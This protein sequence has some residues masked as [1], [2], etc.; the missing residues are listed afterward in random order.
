MTDPGNENVILRSPAISAVVLSICATLV[1]MWIPDWASSDYFTTE[2]VVLLGTLQFLCLVL[3]FWSCLVAYR[4]Y[5][6]LFCPIL[7]AGVTFIVF[8]L[9]LNPTVIYGLRE[10]PQ[11][12]NIG[13]GIYVGSAHDFINPVVTTYLIL[14]I[15][16][17]SFV[18]GYKLLP[19]RNPSYEDNFNG[20]RATL[21]F[22]VIGFSYV[23]FGVIANYSIMGGL[24]SYLAK[25]VHFYSRPDEWIEANLSGGMKWTIM[26]KFLPVGLI[27][28]ALGL[29]LY[30]KTSK[31]MFVLFLIVASVANVFFNCSTGGRGRALTALFFSIILINKYVRQFTMKRLLISF[32]VLAALAFVLGVMRA[33]TYYGTVDAFSFAELIQEGTKLAEFIVKYLTNTVGT[34]VLVNEVD[35]SGIFFH[36]TAFAGLTGLL[37]GPTPLTTQEEIW[38]RTMGEFKVGNAR[39]GPPGELYFNYGLL[40]VIVGFV[41]IGL[42][43][44]IFTRAYVNNRSNVS[45]YG[46]LVAV[47]TAFTAHFVILA[48]LSYLPPYFTF[49]SVPFYAAYFAF[50]YRKC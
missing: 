44:S 35:I 42:L 38:W 1:V 15:A 17:I 49:F 9:L 46:G 37:G 16:W 23:L 33:T 2:R 25:M 24:H 50:R 4:R 27:I 8:H 20:K 7:I 39:F 43:I 11:I 12:H 34:I 21:L 47:Y 29:W 40:G 6:D 22:L 32:F 14:L 5:R 19:E 10:H 48:N 26:M 41:L 18:V 28:L 3:P 13:I 36:K 31:R 45:V 30:L